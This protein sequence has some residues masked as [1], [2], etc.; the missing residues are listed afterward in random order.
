MEYVISA[1]HPDRRPAQRTWIRHEP[2]HHDAVGLQKRLL[3]KGVKFIQAAIRDNG[4]LNFQYILSCL[5][6]ILSVLGFS[7]NS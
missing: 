7:H 4:I 5:I 3:R 1:G 6:L 2:L